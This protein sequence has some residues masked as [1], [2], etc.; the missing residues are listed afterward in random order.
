MEEL[1]TREKWLHEVPPPSVD[2]ADI[3]GAVP[4][5]KIEDTELQ[6]LHL[7]ALKHRSNGLGRKILG[8][9]NARE[10]A[11]AEAAAMLFSS[12]ITLRYYEKIP[13]GQYTMGIAAGWTF[14]RIEPAPPLMPGP[15]GMV[16]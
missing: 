3:P 4:L 16:N 11:I 14:F 13:E 10:I 12:E 9:A 2:I 8:V 6:A 1:V 15:K 5:F 7:I